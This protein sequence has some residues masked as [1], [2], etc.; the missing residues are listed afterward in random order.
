[1]M[2]STGLRCL[3]L[4][5]VLFNGIKAA[6]LR[7]KHRF[8]VDVNEIVEGVHQDGLHRG[9][10]VGGGDDSGMTSK[11]GKRQSKR[12]SSKRDKKGS[13]SWT[14]I[15]DYSMSM[16][17]SMPSEMSMTEA[18]TTSAMPTITPVPSSLP[19]PTALRFCDTFTGTREEAMEIALVE[20]TEGPILTNPAL[21]QGRAYR[22]LL[23]EDPKAADPC[24]YPTIVQRYVLATFYYS[25]FGDLWTANDGWLSA[26]SEC[27]WL[28]ITCSPQKVTSIN[29][30]K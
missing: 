27:E 9:L 19:T 13:M 3:P 18:P 26:S 29:L 12:M 15:W 1:M 24:E 4:L 11:K 14:D 25:T 23:N 16:D 20:I 2:S 28:G 10:G 17:M 22:W 8:M 21:P 5:L 7:R 30:S 6:E